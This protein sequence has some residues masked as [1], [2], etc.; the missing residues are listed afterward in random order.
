MSRLFHTLVVVGSG[1]TI[2]SCGGKTTGDAASGESSTGGG[3]YTNAEGHAGGTVIPT[4]MSDPSA[5]GGSA[6]EDASIPVVDGGSAGPVATGPSTQWSCS[7]SFGQCREVQVDG[8]YVSAYEPETCHSDP[9]RPRTE[10]DCA[11]EEWF[12]C[13]LAF[14]GGQALPVNCSCEPSSTT[15]CG[16][17]GCP[18]P[19]TCFDHSKLCG[20]AIT[21]IR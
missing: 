9:S 7:T 14:I 3:G 1:V 2:S 11:L 16:S 10:A 17:V 21:G 15:G 4:F 19:V 18:G 13:E 6:A 8:S 5:N 20:C 12:A